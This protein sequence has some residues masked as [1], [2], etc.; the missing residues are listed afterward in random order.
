[1]DKTD[2]EGGEI[3]IADELRVLFDELK[4]ELLLVRNDLTLISYDL[5]QMRKQL[6][7]FE[8]AMDNPPPAP[9]DMSGMTV[10]KL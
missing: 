1:M 4:G 7:K 10:I 5:E 8:E 9:M 2:I 6:D 3:M